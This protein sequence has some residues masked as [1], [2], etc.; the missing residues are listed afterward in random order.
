M[1]PTLGED[2]STVKTVEKTTKKL[3]FYTHLV[4]KAAAGLPELS[5]HAGNFINCLT[6]RNCHSRLNLRQPPPSSVSGIDSEARPS[7]SKKI[8]THL[9]AQIM[10]S[11]F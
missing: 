3:E 9:K 7:T 6:L 1:E 5:V 8:M 10:V 11:I 4:D 2:A